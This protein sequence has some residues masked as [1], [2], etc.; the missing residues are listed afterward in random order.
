MKNIYALLI[1]GI[2]LFQT[3]A[4]NPDP[5]LL[6]TTWYLHEVTVDGVTFPSTG[7]IFYPGTLVFDQADMGTWISVNAFASDV[8]YDP[9]LDE[10]ETT[11]P[12][13]TLFTCDIY[14]PLENVYLNEFYYKT[15][16][17]QTFSYEIISNAPGYRLVVTDSEGNF[18]V[19]ANTILGL[20][21]KS[22]DSIS[23]YPNP[24]EDILYLYSESEIITSAAVYT[25]S[26]QL[27]LKIDN[28]SKSIDLS[29]LSGGIY[30]I[31]IATETGSTVKKFIKE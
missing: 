22:T 19:Y 17:P 21:D 5:I 13:I 16:D 26:G 27:L 15:G 11:K 25:S 7:D 1:A 6:D 28:G 8:V 12:T 10:F 14:C 29:S 23:F 31:E 2:C 30:L 4:Q 9:V 18:A 20:D 3:K 24:V